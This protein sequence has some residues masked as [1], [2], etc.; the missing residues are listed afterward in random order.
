MSVQAL[1]MHKNAEYT[2]IDADHGVAIRNTYA[3]ACPKNMCMQ[4]TVQLATDRRFSTSWQAFDAVL[5][6]NTCIHALDM[7]LSRGSGTYSP[8][9]APVRP[10]VGS[11]YTNTNIMLTKSMA[12]TTLLLCGHFVHMNIACQANRDKQPRSWHMYILPCTACHAHK[13]CIQ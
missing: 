4:Q 5:L 7:C 1:H 6:R 10:P 3:E 13:S 12:S 9:C 8:E 11:R 2:S